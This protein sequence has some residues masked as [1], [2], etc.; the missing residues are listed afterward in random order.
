MRHIKGGKGKIQK[1][2]LKAGAFQSYF[3]GGWVVGYNIN[4]KKEAT[5]I[6]KS[7]FGFWE[8]RIYARY[9]DKTHKKLRLNFSKKII[10]LSKKFS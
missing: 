3:K 6:T 1:W 8:E 9:D 10:N 5:A 7:Y 4:I 2:K